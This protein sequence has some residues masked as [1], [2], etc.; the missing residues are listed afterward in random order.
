MFNNSTNINKKNKKTNH[1]YHKLVTT[2][3][4]S[5]FCDRYN[6]VAGFNK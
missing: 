1:S 2:K 5:R 6:N 3:K 4:T